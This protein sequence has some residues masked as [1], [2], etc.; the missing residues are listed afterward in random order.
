MMADNLVGDIV[1]IIACLVAFSY[2]LGVYRM[3]RARSRLVLLIAMSYMVATRFVILALEA[4]AGSSWIE[5][6][7]SIIIVPQYILFAI[8]FGLTY[9]ELRSFRFDVPK[10]AEDTDMQEKRDEFLEAQSVPM[11]AE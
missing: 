2:V 9:Y 10:D 7:R 4:A 1:S 11:E 8:A 6:H 3:V 5:T